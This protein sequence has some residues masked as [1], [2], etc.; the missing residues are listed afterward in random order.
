MLSYTRLPPLVLQASCYAVA[1]HRKLR[2][3]LDSRG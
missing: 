3:F 2:R 1:L